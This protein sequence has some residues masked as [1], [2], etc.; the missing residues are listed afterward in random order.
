VQVVV[1]TRAPL[2]YEDETGFHVVNENSPVP[3]DAAM[4]MTP[5]R[6]S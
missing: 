1:E 3:S 6:T 2:G 5:G 4:R